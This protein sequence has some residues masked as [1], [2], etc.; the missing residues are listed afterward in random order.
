MKLARR[1]FIRLDDE[2]DREAAREAGLQV[3]QEWLG[4]WPASLR[5]CDVVEIE[6]YDQAHTLIA[7]LNGRA[8]ALRTKA[9]RTAA[10][11]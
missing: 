7:Q 1:R 8:C 5:N 10:A 6:H 2:H 11:S 9:K 3:K 4:N